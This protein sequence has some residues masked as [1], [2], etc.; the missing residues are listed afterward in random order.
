[1]AETDTTEGWHIQK[2]LPALHIISTLVL[3]IG[4]FGGF[5]GQIWWAARWVERFELRMAHNEATAEARFNTIEQEIGTLFD[6]GHR[7]SSDLLTAER[8][9]ASIAK[10]QVQ[11]NA[12]LSE[13]IA[14]M[15]TSQR[16]I[17]RSLI[18]IENLLEESERP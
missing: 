3:L 9:A 7:V 2:G 14:I 12:A 5:A 8:L 17:L 13:R 18:R 1:M 10:D 15:E 11:K 16:D 4:V 6:D